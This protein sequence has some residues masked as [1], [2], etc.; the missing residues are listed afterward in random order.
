MRHVVVDDDINAVS[1][2]LMQ[3]NKTIIQIKYYI[4]VISHGN[5][6]TDSKH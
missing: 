1:Q 5:S 2:R 4:N 6:C 3:N